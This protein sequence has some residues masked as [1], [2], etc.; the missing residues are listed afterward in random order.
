MSDP[1]GTF[2]QDAV[3][4]SASGVSKRFGGV[5]ALRDVSLTIRRGEVYGLIGPNGAGKTSF[6]NVLTG[7]YSPDEGRVTFDGR[8]LP[9]GV[10]HRI[11]GAFIQ[12][13]RNYRYRLAIVGDIAQHTNASQSLRDVVFESN[14]GK[15]VF[16]VPDLDAIAVRL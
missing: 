13:I 1:V 11:A 15:D 12:K 16:F 4:L 9:P 8:D 3:L 5:Q 6:F 10:P 14:K 7:L 2:A